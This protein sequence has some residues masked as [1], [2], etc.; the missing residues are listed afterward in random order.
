MSEPILW[1]SRLS[2]YTLKLEAA[3]QYKGIA[4]RRL[5][6]QGSHL[7]NAGVMLRLETAKRLGEISR[8]PVFEERFDEYPL[9]P[10]FSYDKRDFE[11]DSTSILMRMEDNAEGGIGCGRSGGR[12][13]GRSADLRQF[14]RHG[15]S[16][17]R[18]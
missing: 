3:L 16:P 4:Y 17:R 12:R 2:P 6:A 14:R 5:P 7:E 18:P 10:Y 1:G 15:R 8:Y 9:L 11:Y 13:I